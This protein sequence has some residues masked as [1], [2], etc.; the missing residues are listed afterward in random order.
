MQLR[1]NRSTRSLWDPNYT[2]ESWINDK[3]KLIPRLKGW[4][5]SFYPNTP[6][7]ITEYNWGAEN[8]INGATAQ[9][10]ILGIFGREGLDI[11]T[12]WTTPAA[13]TPTYKAIKMYRN[14]DGNKSTF[15]DTSIA[16]SVPNPDSLSAF[17]ALRS[18]DGA[19]TAMVI[20]KVSSSQA[21]TINLANFQSAGRAEVWQLTASNQ[22]TRLAD[23][24]FTGSSFNA[25]LPAQSITLFVVR[26]GTVANAPPVAS[27][28]AT[29]R[30]GIAPLAVSFD[31]RGSTDADGSITSYAWSFGDGTS[32]NGATASHT[33][34]TPGNYVATLT[35][36]DNAGASASTTVAITVTVDTSAINAPTNL[37]A[38]VS[39]RKVILKWADNSGNEQG[40]YIERAPKSTGVFA[41]VAEVGANVR[42]YTQ[43]VSVGTYLYRVQA[44]NRTTG[45]TSAYSNQVQ[46]R[47]R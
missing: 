7:A 35:V 9:A 14:Y 20:N 5:A 11:A 47:V 33:Y 29:P 40:F 32:A 27:A 22:I 15:G 31:G 24:T 21:A 44:F 12:R 4:V 28:A 26:G 37:T 46:A 17:A 36:T 25:T 10:D 42:K 39:G 16:A 13:S 8:H 41:R 45:R 6:V 18:S 30:S 3:V 43:T 23:I 19:L 34:S 2:D 38:S 1:R